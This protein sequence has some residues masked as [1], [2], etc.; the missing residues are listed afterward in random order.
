MVIR[1]AE[2]FQ[3][4]PACD[5]AI[6]KLAIVAPFRAVV[7]AISRLAD[8]GT[9]AFTYDAG[10][11]VTQVVDSAYGTITR[12][13]TGLDQL[14][15]ETTP[16]GTVSYTYDAAGRRATLTVAGQTQMAYGYDNANHLTSITQGTTV[17]GF[18]YDDAGRRTTTTYPNGVAAA[19]GY[20]AASRLTSISF[21]NGGST[22]GT[23]TYAYD[24][25]D[26][27]TLI[28]GTLGGTT[29]PAAVTTTVVDAANRLTT[30]DSTAL[31]YDLAGNLTSDGTNT[32]TWDARNQ[33]IAISGGTTASFAYDPFGRRSTRTVGSTTTKYLYDGLNS[34]QELDGSLAPTANLITGLGLDETLVRT[35]GAGSFSLLADALGS[36]V[37]L[38]NGSGAVTTQ[39]TY[40]PFGQVT[41]TG[42]ASTNPSQF[43][44]RE[45]DGTGL[46]Y[47]RARYYSPTLGRFISDDP[48]G[49]AGG[50]N[51]TA[52]VGDNPATLS[53]PRGLQSLT[54][55]GNLPILMSPLLPGIGAGIS[56]SITVG[57]D[58]SISGTV[59]VGVGT[60]GV[61]VTVTPGGPSS[62][63][64]LSA[65]LNI[66]GTPVGVSGTADGSFGGGITTEGPWVGWNYTF[67]LLPPP[68]SVRLPFMPQVPQPPGT[69]GSSGTPWPQYPW[70]KPKC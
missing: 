21:T 32:Y 62:G 55:G 70:Q 60:P 44:G 31:T 1:G 54:I 24:V 45:N 20:D 57:G 49:L 64:S 30:R 17:V 3:G 58:G 35:D 11:R 15:S 52:Y 26:N 50:I 28:G 25:A 8:T 33:L 43:T 19:Y 13:Y 37:A 39:Y 29:L 61:S 9:T 53:D 66:P 14:S 48:L 65:S 42:A 63:G 69:P 22:L 2:A 56:G 59:G 46:Y 10:N 47:Y 16:Q 5:T 12:S 51:A 4:D 23:L 41:V 67:P 34:V 18:A 40:G 68:G 7:F 38:T 36:I 27:R 6:A